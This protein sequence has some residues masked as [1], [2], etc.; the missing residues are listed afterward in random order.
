MTTH[1]SDSHVRSTSNNVVLAAIDD[2]GSTPVVLMTAAQLSLANGATDLHLVHAVVDLPTPWTLGEGI[3]TSVHEE[4]LDTARRFLDEKVA[5]ARTL[6]PG[7]VHGHLESGNPS[8]VIL[9]LATRL[10]AASIVVGTHEYTAIGRL[11]LGSVGATVT[12]RAHCSV[13][14]ARPPHY[15][16]DIEKSAKEPVEVQIE[17]PCKD[18]VEVQRATNGARMWCDTHSRHFPQAHTH[19]EYPQNFGAGSQLIRP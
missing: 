19:Y 6:F 16:L 10:R 14:I 8:D 3:A 2:S 1:A 9:N 13:T 11:L 12:R 5:E 7:D 4:H 15:P 17:A 18:C